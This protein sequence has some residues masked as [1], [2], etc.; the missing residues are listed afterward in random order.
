MCEETSHGSN[1]E[2]FKEY[3]KNNRGIFYKKFEE[4]INNEN[5]IFDIYWGD[6]NIIFDKQILGLYPMAFI[7]FPRWKNDPNTRIYLHEKLEKK[8]AKA[9]E[10]VLAHEI[11]HFWLFNILGINHPKTTFRL[12]ER[13]TEEWADYF[14]Y[15]F[16]VKYR[17]MNKLEQLE[18]VLKEVENFQ[19]SIYN[20]DP[21]IYYKFSFVD[22]IKDLNILEN[23]I[24]IAYNNGDQI[25]IQM[26]DTLELILNL[27]KELF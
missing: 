15:R 16:F 4:R 19:R 25:I 18:E 14:A 6:P 20:M 3:Y 17:N 9:F 1:K 26:L 27:V 13:E 24:Q 5:I 23:K 7:K 10:Y 2:S 11:G 12:G 22:K 8:N 21:D